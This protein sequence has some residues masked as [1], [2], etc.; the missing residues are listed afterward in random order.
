MDATL[1][2]ITL[3]AIFITNL[4]PQGYGSQIGEPGV[5]STGFDF[6]NIL[7]TSQNLSELVDEMTNQ[8]TE[9]MRNLNSTDVLAVP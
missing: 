7:Y 4:Y 9:Y 1:I 5:P 3:Q 6:S 8:M 2:S